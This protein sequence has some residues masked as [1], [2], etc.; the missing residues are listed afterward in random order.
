[1]IPVFA[2]PFGEPLVVG[3]GEAASLIDQSIQ[4]LFQACSSLAEGGRIQVGYIAPS[5]NRLP[6]FGIIVAFVCT[7]VLW[8]LLWPGM[9][10]QTVT[11]AG[12]AC[13]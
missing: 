10:Q 3:I 9:H 4:A 6:S 13:L 8:L 1:M 5:F 12:D 7:K 2:Q 11:R